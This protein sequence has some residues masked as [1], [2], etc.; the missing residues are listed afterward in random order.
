[1]IKCDKVQHFRS[2]R[3]VERWASTVNNVVKHQH[4]DEPGYVSIPCPVC[5][6]DSGPELSVYS[7]PAP[8]TAGLVYPKYAFVPDHVCKSMLFNFYFNV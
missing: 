7:T 2:V 8:F 6:I 1:M 4:L 5:A 3:V